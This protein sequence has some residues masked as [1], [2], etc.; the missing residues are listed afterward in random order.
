MAQNELLEQ[1]CV[2]DVFCEGLARIDHVGPCR[3]LIFIVRDITSP[4]YKNVVAKII[5]PAEAMFEIAQMVAADRPVSAALAAI[6]HDA[7][8]N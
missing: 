7:L 1:Y 4:G 8:A 6:P 5:V 3:R 2:T